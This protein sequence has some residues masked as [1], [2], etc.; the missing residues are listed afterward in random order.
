MKGF[1]GGWAEFQKGEGMGSIC[2]LL[3]CK[4]NLWLFATVVFRLFGQYLYLHHRMH[5]TPRPLK[6]LCHTTNQEMLIG[7]VTA[8]FELYA[9]FSPLT[10][11]ATAMNAITKLLRWIKVW[12]LIY[13][14][15]DIHIVLF[16]YHPLTFGFVYSVI[17]W[18]CHFSKKGQPISL[19]MFL[20]ALY[21]VLT[22]TWNYF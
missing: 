7:S 9:A 19:E 22:N 4:R 6:R 11:K 1:T 3:G 21:N 12:L 2:P 18:Y 5:S 8:G 10:S 13:F 17:Y 14:F 20:L 16:F 15:L